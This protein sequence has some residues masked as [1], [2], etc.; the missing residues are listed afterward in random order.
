MGNQ[1][2]GACHSILWY[3][4]VRMAL[5]LQVKIWKSLVIKSLQLSP[6]GGLKQANIIL[7]FTQDEV[8]AAFWFAT[9]ASEMGL[10]SALGIS[11]FV[12]QGQSFFA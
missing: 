4:A 8:N 2:T 9:R 3:F 5:H 7:L 12:P 11:Y 10:S 6:I 1:A